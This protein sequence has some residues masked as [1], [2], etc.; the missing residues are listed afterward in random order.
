LFGAAFVAGVAYVAYGPGTPS[1]LAG[2]VTLVLAAGSR[3]SQ[4]VG[5]TATE[6]HFFR[7][8]WLDA[9]KR[10][11][12][13]EDYAA[14]R[15]GVADLPV[16]DRLRAGIRFDNVSFRYPGAEKLVL[17]KVSVL[18]PAGGVVAVVGE[19][20]AGKSTLVKL[21]CRFYEPTS[22][23]ITVDGVELAGLPPADW[24][25]RL[26]GTF[27][28]FVRFEF[29]AGVTVGLGDLPRLADPGALGRA[30][31]RAGA[32][33]VVRAFPDGL[34][35]QLGNVWHGGVEVSFGQWQALALARGF[36]RDEPLVL[37]LD[38]PTAALDAE[39]E[40]AL[41]ERYSAAARAPGGRQSGQITVLVS[42]RF[43]T[44]R[45]ADVIIVLDGAQVLEVGSHDELM[46]LDN[47]YAELY[48]LQQAAYR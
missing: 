23:Q 47:R 4:Y 12:W 37:I 31:E 22:G 40:H 36:M 16:P 24:R 8:I 38:E 41:F 1:E 9:A 33:D 35:T 20:G 34:D 2:A 45:M 18:L 30:V 44:I 46:A 32:G 43:S 14:A 5:Q 21:L 25:A 17:D 6:T 11:T 29:R 13:L 7:S 48:H 3:L 27:Q 26:A 19:N 28:D 10:L 15:A 42:H 39:T